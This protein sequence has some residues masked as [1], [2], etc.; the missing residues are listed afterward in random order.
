MAY[1]VLTNLDMNDGQVFNLVL[2]VL[3]SDPP[4]VEGKVYYNSSVDEIRFYDGTQWLSLGTLGAGAPPSGSAGGD[5]SGSYPNPDIAA[6]VIV[7]ADVSGSAAIAQ[8]KIAN[9][10]SDLSGKAST[11]TT[12]TAGNGLTGGGSLAVNRTLDVGAGTGISVAADAVSL[13]TT[14]TDGRYVNTSGDTMSGPLDMGDNAITSVATPTNDTDAATKAYVDLI[15][16]GLAVKNAARLV[17]TGNVTQSGLSSIDGVSPS[18]GDRILC[19]GQTNPIQNGVYLAQAGSWSR[20]LDSNGTGEIEDGTL[21]PVSEGSANQDTLWICTS[22]GDDPWEPGTSGSTWTRFSGIQDL[23][24]GAGLTK[25][26]TQIDVVGDANLDVQADVV[27]V[28]SA[29]KWTTARTL[30]LTGDV[31]GSTSI[32]GSGNASIATTIQGGGSLPQHYAANVGAG[33]AVTV[34]HALGTRDVTVEVY[35]NSAP[36]DTVLCDVERTDTNNVTLR[37]ASAVTA[38]AYRVVVQ[39]R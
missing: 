33:T 27:N 17:A 2:H 29:P 11:G 19:A 6:G 3:A 32:D 25:T 24:A 13:D 5:L 15:S 28:L 9:L 22:T 16:Q 20:A 26:G 10:T 7:D 14:Y 4:G 23:V 30:S 18:I 34:N 37:F 1:N 21:V 35:R 8:S 31:T 12:V 36:Y 38:N 39:G